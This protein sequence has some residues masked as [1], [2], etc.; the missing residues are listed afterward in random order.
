VSNRPWVTTGETCELVIAL[1]M[2]G[3]HDDAA[4]LFEWVQHLRAPD[5]NYWTGAT[6]PD[7]TLWPR[8][9]TTWNAGA[10][11]L[12]WDVLRGGPTSELF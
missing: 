12:A 11:L 9:Q 10:V 3:R 4:R 6:F 7:G 2:V 5:G 1:A 8:E